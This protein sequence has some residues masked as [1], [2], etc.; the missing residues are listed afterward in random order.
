MLFSVTQINVVVKPSLEPAGLEKAGAILTLSFDLLVVFT[1]MTGSLWI[2][3]SQQFV[4][5]LCFPSRKKHT[6]YEH[7]ST[8]SLPDHRWAPG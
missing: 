2:Y 4:P 8:P 7:M 1:L 3:P 6:V 5:F